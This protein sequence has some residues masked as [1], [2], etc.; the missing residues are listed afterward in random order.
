MNTKLTG[1]I[2]TGALIIGSMTPGLATNVMAEEESPE[3]DLSVAALSQYVW[4]GYAFSKDSLIIQP[5]MTVGYKGFGF[6]LWGNLDTDQVGMDSESFN[7]NETD[8]TI[9]YDGSV[10]M[11]GYS[12]GYI[13]YDLDGIEDTTEIYLGVSLDTLLSPSLTL[14]MDIANVPGWY[15]NLSVGHSIALGE[16]MSLD[17]GASIGYLDDDAD[18]SELHDGVLSV[19]MPV[20]VGKYLTVTP[21]LHAS[22]ALSSK[23]DDLLKAANLGAISDE[24]STFIY[25]GI[26]ASFAF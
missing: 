18:Y 5:S 14:Y 17:L 20:A 25:G 6:N 8:M 26:S 19:A 4:R 24:E 21:E 22:L 3:A 23:A 13:Y 2:V 15:A 1:W 9:S 7:W 10:G 12:V 16:T 11:V